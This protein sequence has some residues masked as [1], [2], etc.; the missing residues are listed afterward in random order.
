[1]QSDWF[2]E[3][4]V[5]YDHALERR[6]ATAQVSVR[7]RKGRK[8]LRRIRSRSRSRKSAYD[9][10]KIKNRRGKRSHKHD[11]IGV[12]RIR[13]FPFPPTSTYNSVAYVPLMI[14]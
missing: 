13:T 1:M 7:I 8:I 3:R 5:F 9:L 4:A 6:L 10:V 2:R 14:K 12:R 11:G